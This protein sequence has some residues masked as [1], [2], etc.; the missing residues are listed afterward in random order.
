MESKV[1]ESSDIFLINI[2][3]K[4]AHYDRKFETLPIF[5][6]INKKKL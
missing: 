1:K 4:S 5:I 6:R 2:I 3:K